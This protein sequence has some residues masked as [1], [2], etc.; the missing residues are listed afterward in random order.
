MKYNKILT[1][2]LFITLTIIFNNSLAQQ[3]AITLNGDKII[4]ND[5]GSW[6]YSKQNKDSGYIVKLGIDSLA[7]DM[8]IHTIKINLNDYKYKRNATHLVKSKKIKAGLY[9]NNKYWGISRGLVNEQSEYY[10]FN[11]IDD[12][13]AS[14]YTENFNKI[15]YIQLERNMLRNAQVNMPDAFL[16]MSEYRIVNGT[17]V[18]YTD[19]IGTLNKFKSETLKYSIITNDGLVELSV[20]NSDDKI[21]KYREVYED[22]L[23]GLV[24]LEK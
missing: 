24:L 9:V 8:L 18:L 5:D 1:H 7:D 6:K 23:N 12:G 4:L 10:F 3:T 20:F 14:F 22:F 21:E 15:S 2:L 11:K 17:R 16:K 13:Y 19:V